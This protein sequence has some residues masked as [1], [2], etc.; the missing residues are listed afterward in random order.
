[1]C[2]SKSATENF[3]KRSSRFS[4]KSADE[5][6]LVKIRAFKVQYSNSVSRSDT[7]TVQVT[8]VGFDAVIVHTHTG[9]VF[10]NGGGGYRRFFCPTSMGLQTYVVLFKT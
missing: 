7:D 1:V 3:G 9:K 10:Q 6:E 2:S 4:L 8:G 5:D